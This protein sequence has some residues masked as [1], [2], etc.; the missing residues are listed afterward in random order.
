MDVGGSQFDMDEPLAIIFSMGSA[1]LC[2][3]LLAPICLCVGIHGTVKRLV[4]SKCGLKYKIKFA[5]IGRSWKPLGYCSMCLVPVVGAIGAV[6]L[7]LSDF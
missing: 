2:Y 3:P 6:K 5:K 1:Q 4:K 7:G